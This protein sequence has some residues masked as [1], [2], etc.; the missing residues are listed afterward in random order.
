[1]PPGKRLDLDI[2]VLAAA[3][4]RRTEHALEH[5]FCNREHTEFEIAPRRSFLYSP[6]SGEN[7]VKRA[8]P[9]LCKKLGDR[10]VQSFCFVKLEIR[11]CSE[12]FA[13]NKVNKRKK[14][15][16]QTFTF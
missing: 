12:N 1:M 6:I 16:C 11:T 3:Y 2:V 7:R 14:N 10:E 8:G 9:K 5:C 4:T 13:Q 15:D